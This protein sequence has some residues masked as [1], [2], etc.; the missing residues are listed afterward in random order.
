MTL[1]RF[2]LGSV[3]LL[4]A[5]NLLT[6]CLAGKYMSNVAL[7]PAEHGPADIERTRAKA[8]S[9]SP[10]AMVWFDDLV[11]KDIFKHYYR[12]DAEGHK[13]HAIYAPAKDPEN[14]QERPSSST[15]IRTTILSSCTSSGCTGMSSTIT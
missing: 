7:K 10:G 1:K 5:V 8:D 12:T 4:L 11:K 13:L 9:L 6:G 15:A 3:T 2:I 14:A